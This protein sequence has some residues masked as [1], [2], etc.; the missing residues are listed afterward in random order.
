MQDSVQ[1]GRQKSGNYNIN[2]TAW[3]LI[4]GILETAGWHFRIEYLNY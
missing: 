3:Y 1:N 2:Y 4:I